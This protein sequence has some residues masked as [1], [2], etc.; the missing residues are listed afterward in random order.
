MTSLRR[1]A[2]EAYGV[3][4]GGEAE[5]GHGAAVEAEDVVEEAHILR[6]HCNPLKVMTRWT[7]T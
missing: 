3:G 7:R 5:P 6:R 2:G 4:V 1:Q